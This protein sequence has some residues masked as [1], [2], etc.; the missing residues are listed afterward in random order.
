MADGVTAT[1]TYRPDP[2]GVK[3]LGFMAGM[4]A[5]T[6]DVATKY[7]QLVVSNTPSRTGRTRGKV[8][9]GQTGADRDSTYTTVE[10]SRSQ[11][12]WIEFGTAS[13]RPA[14]PFRRSA[15]QMGLRF[16]DP[17]RGGG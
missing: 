11:W 16:E 9:V 6:A 1:V 17:G 10:G 3:E 8:R 13:N 14:A 12:H 15:A 5:F 4:R 7:A 2:A